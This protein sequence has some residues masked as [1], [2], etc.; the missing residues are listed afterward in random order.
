MIRLVQS[1]I[2]ES[3]R[4]EFRVTLILFLFK[5]VTRRIQSRVIIKIA[6]LNAVERRSL[7]ISYMA[8]SM[9]HMIIIM[10]EAVSK[11]NEEFIHLVE[12]P[13]WENL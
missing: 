13:F 9:L 5:R 6:T 7:S 8:S 11:K 2:N 1:Q 10:Q 12:G 3:R 4:R